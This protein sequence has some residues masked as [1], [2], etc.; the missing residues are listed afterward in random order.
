VAQEGSAALKVGVPE[1]S[2][3]SAEREGRTLAEVVIAVDPAKR[4]HTL[5]VLDGRERVL[6]TLR[7]QNTT[8]GYRALRILTGS[9]GHWTTM[10]PRT[11]QL[12]L[13]A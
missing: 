13:P 10:E 1:P 11:R 3:T 8:A 6:A 4:S 12:G 7:V 2:T 5:E 9:G